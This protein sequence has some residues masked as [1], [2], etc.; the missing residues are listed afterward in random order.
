MFLE[1]LSVVCVPGTRT[2]YVSL[3]AKAALI[4]EVLAYANGE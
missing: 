4:D 2:A 1:D 3:V